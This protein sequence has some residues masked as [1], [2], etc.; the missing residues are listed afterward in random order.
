MLERF[1]VDMAKQRPKLP[2]V[3][4]A[5]A[6]EAAAANASLQR[7][8]PMSQSMPMLS[9]ALLAVP[10]SPTVANNEPDDAFRSYDNELF[11][12]SDPGFRFS[13]LGV[14]EAPAQEAVIVETAVP[15]RAVVLSPRGATLSS[16]RGSATPSSDKPSQ[17]L[18][19]PQPTTFG[20]S[21]L[22]NSPTMLRRAAPPP[23]LVP[24][25]SEAPMTAAMASR[26]VARPA[27]ATDGS[28]AGGMT[29]SPSQQALAASMPTQPAALTPSRSMSG[30]QSQLAL[31][32][33][34]QAGPR[35]PQ[36]AQMAM[37]SEK[38]FHVAA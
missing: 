15:L 1:I 28:N 10:P 36:S 5:K 6:A 35:T 31:D 30:S 38:P 11:E 20:P 7:L 26:A 8:L 19:L 25:S 12:N 17:S 33:L 37:L 4:E 34:A 13:D 21:A 18:G 24:A 16:P 3:E 29:K 22:A 23:L 2:Q 27:G 14:G 32:T 9:E